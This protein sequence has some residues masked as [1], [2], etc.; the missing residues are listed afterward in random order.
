VTGLSAHAGGRAQQAN[1]GGDN[2]APIIFAGNPAPA[3][4]LHQLPPG[5]HDFSGRT[6]DIAEVER[7]I[8]SPG[9]GPSVVNVFGAPGIGKSALLVHVAHRLAEKLEEIQLYAELGELD[10]QVPTSTQVLQRF[11]AALDP[12]TTGIPVSAQELPARFRSLLSGRRCLVVLDNAQSP[13]QIADLIPGTAKSAVLVTSRAS[14]AA[15][16]GI[17]PYHLGL[18]SPAESLELLS[19]V[20]RRTWPEGQVPD[21]AHRLINQCGRLPM[22]LR[23]VGAI[24]K[25]KPHWTLEKV[26]ADLAGEQTRLAKLAEG[27]LDIRSC[28][29]VSYR[30]LG[31]EEA[32]A[33]RL[34][35]LLPLAQFKLR[36]AASFLRQSE[37]YAED[38]IEALVDAQLLETDDG[39]YFRFH[40][41]LRLYARERSQAA[42]DDPDGARA[43]RFLQELMG[44]FMHAY[45]RCIREN[46]W[47]VPRPDRISLP[48]LA[49]QDTTLQAAPDA[50]YVPT[51]L[52]PVGR[53]AEP[54]CAWHDLLGQ[55]Q[56]ILILGA[57]GTGKTV[58]ADR[59]CYEI[60]AVPYSSTRLYDV[61]C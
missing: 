6:A 53:P 23:I 20:S 29:E 48:S 50:L 41:L 14:L 39:R 56:R 55:H 60:A 24:L 37:H 31:N 54:E 42:H 17:L 19:S 38:V 40:D 35:S 61:G 46:K 9:G 18:M 26:A 11:V 4:S 57:A 47:T 36:H 13:D 8:G 30:H 45:T 43:A 2:Y 10:G 1:F 15:V 27:P 51:R 16:Q 34:L 12:A 33:F 49:W 28:F 25:K 21:A 32:Q 7:M 58:L 5:I 44:E 3:P 52:T 22:A 59:I